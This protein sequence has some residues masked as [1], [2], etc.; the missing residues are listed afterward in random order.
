[1]SPLQEMGRDEL[2]TPRYFKVRRSRADPLGQHWNF[3][4]PSQS[5]KQFDLDGTHGKVAEPLLGTYLGRMCCRSTVH[6][7]IVDT[8]ARASVNQLI[9][10]REER[11]Q[12]QRHLTIRDY[13]L[14]AE[15]P[16]HPN[17]QG[18]RRLMLS[19][20]VCDSRGL[21][22]PQLLGRQDRGSGSIKSADVT[23]FSC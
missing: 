17:R 12:R 22:R 20:Q 18:L 1:M 11:T 23:L 4:L 9:T 6:V 5:C 13:E 14:P 7:V 3:S 10:S 16:G 15:T 2:P 21:S 19:E 8:G